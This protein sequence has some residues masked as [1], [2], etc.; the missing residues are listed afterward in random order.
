MTAS[1]HASG[2]RTTRR[3]ALALLGLG[4]AAA[5]APT[6]DRARSADQTAEGSFEHGVASGDPAATSVVLWTRVTP[7][8]AGPVTVI[9]EIDTDPAFPAP[10]SGTVEARAVRDHTVKVVL[11]G[12]APGMDYHFRFR[13]GASVS[14]VGRTRTL[15]DG[16][17]ESVRFAV[18]SCANLEHGF[19]NVY[20]L[21]ARRGSEFD[22]LL[23]LGDYYYEYGA[24]TY[25]APDKPA[26]R[27]HEPAH[28][29]LDLADYRTRHAQYRRD[30][31]LQAVTAAMPIIPI[32]DDHETAND[33]WRD[34]AQNHDPGE[35]SWEDRKQAALRAYFEWMPVREPEPGRAAET[36]YRSFQFGDLLTLVGVETRLTARA[37]PLVIEEFVDEVVADVDAFRA[38]YLNDESREMLG[39]EQQDFIVDTFARSKRDGVRWR[40][41][42]NQVIL[43]RIMTPDFTPYVTQEATQAIEKDWPGIHDFLTLSK[44]GLPFYPDSWDG[45][46]AARERFFAGLDAAGV[47]DVLTVT[48]DAHEF[49]ANRLTR[50]DGT[51]M[52]AEFVTSSVSSKT[53]TA[54]LGDATAQHNLLMTRENDDARFYTALH[55]G[56]LEIELDRDGGRATMHAVD[57]VNDRDYGTFRAARFDIRKRRKDGKDTLRIARPRGLSLTQRA[58]FLGLG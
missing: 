32:W 48:G 34:G 26:G 56:Y 30:P 28:E 41:L 31:N 8:D 39:A 3:N 37:Q 57:T 50:D 23:H 38:Q 1:R 17:P 13:A 49:W 27:S 9:W 25:D 45:Y 18:V 12:L 55:N 46:P 33:S 14:P 7:D 29:I 58:L 20:D 15:P 40:M 2:L 43:G 5:C 22:A 10:M 24:D 4:G 47:N 53:L 52:G 42:A 16:S 19:F 35:G 36:F 6:V 44:Y 11:E 54:Y 51:H 21:I